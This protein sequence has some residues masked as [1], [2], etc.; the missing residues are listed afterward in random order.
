MKNWIVP[1][2][3]AQKFA[4]NE[5]VSACYSVQCVTP[6]GNKN[7]TSLWADNG[8]GVF[9]ESVDTL[10]AARAGYTFTGCNGWITVIGEEKPSQFNGFVVQNGEAIPVY[11]WD[12]DTFDHHTD[13]EYFLL[14]QTDSLDKI[15]EDGNKS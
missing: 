13:G 14:H 8:D 9:D 5:Y 6:N 2:A 3:N 12:G 4:A 1:A 11:W 10:L 7:S 15:I